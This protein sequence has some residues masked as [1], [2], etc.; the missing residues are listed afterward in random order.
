MKNKYILFPLLGIL[1]A[2][3]GCSDDRIYSSSYDDGRYP[4][5]LK[6]SIEQVNVTRADDSGF[7]DEDRIGVYMVDFQNGVPGAL[8]SGGNH[9]DNIE[10]VFNE[11]SFS[12]ESQT[13]LFFKDDDT[14][15]DFYSY[16]PYLKDIQDV[17]AVPF[18]VECNQS[19][20]DQS[21][22]MSCYEKSDLLWAKTA[23][24]DP[25]ANVINLLFNHVFAGVEV[26]L[27]EG[28]GFESGEWDGL[29]KSVL[30]DG[31]SR[32]CIFDLSTGAVTSRGS[33]DGKAI[34][35]NPVANGFRAVVVP[36]VLKTGTDL[37]LITVGTTAYK[38]SKNIDMTY[39]GGKLHKF[40]FE[41]SK[42][43]MGG[44]YSFSLL[45]ESIT[46]WE[47]DPVSHEGVSR[48]YQI[49]E[50]K[51]GERLENVLMDNNIDPKEIINLKLIGTM[52][53][54]DFYF[55]R[56]NMRKIQA[57]NLKDLKI[58]GDEDCI[59]SI[60][61]TNSVTLKHLVL[62]DRLERI[63]DFAF[64]G[65]ILEGSLKIPDGVKYIGAHAFTNYWSEGA[66]YSALPGGKLLANNNLTGTLEIPSSVEYIG[67]EAFRECNF[68]G[69]LN[70]PAKLRFLGSNAFSGCRNFS[71]KIHF[72][73]TLIEIGDTDW[74]DLESG[75]GVF[76]GMS[77]LVGDFELP[78]NLKVINGFGGIC[79][80]NV[81]M[82]ENATA[83]G[84][85][86]FHNSKIKGGIVISE[87]IKDIGKYAFYSCSAPFI[88]LPSSLT[89]IRECSFAR[90]YNLSDTLTI[91]ANVEV[92]ENSAF[93]NCSKITSLKL[94]A[95]L[96]YIGSFAF[97]MCTSLEYI[98][99]EAKEPPVIDDGTFDG[100]NKDN[101]T[102]EVPEESVDAYRNAP[103]WSEFRRISAY[104][105]FVARPSKYNVLN[106]GGSKEIILN[107]DA[108]WELVDCPAWCHVDKT[109]GNKKTVIT[110]S[111]D[112][113][114][115]GNPVRT[116]E[117]VFRLKGNNDYKTHINVGQYDY[118]YEEDSYVS[119]QKATRGNGID[120]FLVGDGYDAVD[121]SS[122][123]LMKDMRQ[124]MEYFFAVEPYTSY[125][126]YFNVYTGIALSE[127]SGV[128]ELNKWRNTKFHTVVPKT[129][130]LRISAD[131]MAALDY[132]AEICEPIVS[133]PEPKV[134]VILL[135]N[136]DGY[137]GVT[138]SVGESFCSLVTKSDLR[139]PNDAR[140]LVQHEA[141]GHGIGWLADEYVY[142]ADFIQKCSCNDCGHVA[143]LIAD[144]SR[145]FG[146]NV[147]LIGKYKEVPWTHLIF[148]PS[149]GDIVDIYEGGYFHKNGVYRSEYN[150][151]MNDNVP[152]FS[153]WSR[154]LIV[155]RIMKLSGE[156]FSLEAFY[157]K[158]KRDVGRDFTTSSRGGL[159]I[160]S[161]NIHGNPPVFIKN[162][163]FGKKG[164]RK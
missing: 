151:C 92:I 108:E 81:L 5:N 14:P 68:T 36:Q 25:K 24:A 107:A 86:A 57:L 98:H 135:T 71:G 161:T 45:D 94:P 60:A 138:Y 116:G 75:D 132:C 146:M 149:Y 27:I 65:T 155:E 120:L 88:A 10:F 90:C 121:I 109:A 131:W 93:E 28:D 39:L 154:Q 49:V 64:A 82:P 43:N 3:Y 124:T 152:Y 22:E 126:E 148:N 47:S 106:K 114:E 78:R 110:L 32:D 48:T 104:R 20:A 34:V 99:C 97:S 133:K 40:T 85:Y 11:S 80:S 52:H 76:Y 42:K 95:K 145:G 111:I 62:P 46:A 123:L 29:N 103:G 147:S 4:V 162:Y 73:E 53:S 37:M 77:G 89:R 50:I 144:Q 153:S 44:E 143:E 58:I 160:K 19:A 101:F 67:T 66:G 31:T 139:Y 164:G 63:E 74:S 17:N 118:E 163:V 140:G 129:C 122:G 30:V 119:L 1:L 55:I 158:D 33:Y 125:R 21:K 156:S 102:V 117:V 8:V 91:P 128:E 12:W 15:A 157:S 23:A 61:M 150:S 9:A 115:K 134:G 35:S 79:A 105:N 38:F 6:A 51:K 26:R 18:S 136:Y 100:V 141:G 54:E 7:A 96:T 87:N 69:P 59:P 142:H 72:P 127:D 70:L 41:V 16:Y 112:R 130:G 2:L 13:S 84:A 83:I 113:M 159:T 137:D 56:D